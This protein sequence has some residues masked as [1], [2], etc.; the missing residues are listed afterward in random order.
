MADFGES[1][2]FSISNMPSPEATNDCQISDR[3]GIREDVVQPLRGDEPAIE[4]AMQC[5]T[6]EASILIPSTPY[7][8]RR[9]DDQEEIHYSHLVDG[10]GHVHLWNVLEPQ[11]SIA[12]DVA[13]VSYYARYCVGRRGESVI[14]CAKET[15]VL[16]CHEGDWKIL[17]MHNSAAA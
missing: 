5:F 10:R 7:R 2:A 11:V 12:G 6:D 1:V 17:H 15:L 16:V 8:L 13:V 14:K 9:E 4:R 3:C